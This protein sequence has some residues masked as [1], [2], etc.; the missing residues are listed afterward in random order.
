MLIKFVCWPSNQKCLL[1]RLTLLF[2]ILLISGNGDKS[3]AQSVE[4]SVFDG[5]QATL[6]LGAPSLFND[7]C[8]AWDVVPSGNVEG[9]ESVLT[10]VSAISANDM[11]AVGYSVVGGVARTL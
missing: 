5:D 4:L 3:L 1:A 2:V 6:Y 10:A 8:P 9:G 7:P 11:W